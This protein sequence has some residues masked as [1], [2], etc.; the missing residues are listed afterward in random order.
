MANNPWWADFY[1]VFS[2]AFR[3]DPY[4]TKTNGELTGAG[5]PSTDNMP[6]LRGGDGFGGGGLVKLRDSNDFLDLTTVTNRQSRYKE[7]ERLRVV[8]E[9]EMA[10]T[11]I[12]DEA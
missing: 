4:W 6:D 2:G 7:Y 9:I 3:K 10:M 8:A 5:Y 12:A 11:T 1:K